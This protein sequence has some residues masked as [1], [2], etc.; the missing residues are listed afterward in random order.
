MYIQEEATSW[1]K[2]DGW[3]HFPYASCMSMFI[4]L[5][6]PA[7]RPIRG[8]SLARKPP[9]ANSSLSSAITRKRYHAALPPRTS[10]ILHLAF[11]LCGAITLSSY[12]WKFNIYQ[13]EY[14][15]SGRCAFFIGL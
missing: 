8:N 13:L 4:S 3:A 1:R 9:E 15:G 5:T 14:F 12:V 2:L 10:K 11:T 6:F 7:A